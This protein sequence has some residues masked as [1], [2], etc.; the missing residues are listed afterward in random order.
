M[1]ILFASWDNKTFLYLRPAY[2]PKP[3]GWGLNNS[4]P[5]D[6]AIP[7]HSSAPKYRE[8]QILGGRNRA[9]KMQKRRI[10][11]AQAGG[12]VR[13]IAYHPKGRYWE[14]RFNLCGES[15]V[16]PTALGKS[17]GLQ[18][19]QVVNVECDIRVEQ[20]PFAYAERAQLEG[21]ARRL[22]ICLKGT[23][24]R[25]ECKGQEFQKWIQCNSDT[26]VLRAERLIDLLSD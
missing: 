19:N 3:D 15:I 16:I 1:T 23:Y 24:R 9:A 17:L 26:A 12:A 18:Y 4:N 7:G 13:I 10:A 2:L 20:H 8:G 25:G 5:L 14:F 22:G 21:K 6:F 11:N